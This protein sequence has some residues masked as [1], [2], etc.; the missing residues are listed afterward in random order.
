M[1]CDGQQRRR[2]LCCSSV[3]V[4]ITH[5]ERGRIV[6]LGHR[7][8]L[9]LTISVLISVVISASLV[10]ARL[11]VQSFRANWQALKIAFHPG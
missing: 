9:S 7:V 2:V 4:Q 5:V 6:Q 10:L 11:S 8:F 3:I 1:T